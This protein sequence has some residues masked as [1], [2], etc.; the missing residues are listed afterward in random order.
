MSAIASIF[1]AV[2]CVIL[3]LMILHDYT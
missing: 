1:L 2:A 3:V